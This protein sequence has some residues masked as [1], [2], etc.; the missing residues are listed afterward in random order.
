[1]MMM[2]KYP[3]AVQVIADH[4]HVFHFVWNSIAILNVLVRLFFDFICSV[5]E[6]S[7]FDFRV[8]WLIN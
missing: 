5:A 6:F 1:M 7:K 2:I 3:E 8:N 4:L